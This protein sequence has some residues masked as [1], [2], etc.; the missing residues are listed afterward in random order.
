MR[1]RATKVYPYSVSLNKNDVL[2]MINRLSIFAVS[3]NM[4]KPYG[5]F[6]FGKDYVTVY[7]WNMRNKEVIYYDD[8][9]LS[10]EDDVKLSLFISLKSGYGEKIFQ[11]LK[12]LLKKKNYNT[13]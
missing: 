4:M 13:K 3:G 9:E 5:Q 6:E 10:V 8:G 7:D 11:K 12:T 2:Q 1:G